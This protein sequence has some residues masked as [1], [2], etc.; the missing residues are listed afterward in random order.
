MGI[1]PTT[2]TF[3]AMAEEL[4][5]SVWSEVTGLFG[6]APRH[7]G[8]TPEQALLNTPNL[9]PHFIPRAPMSNANLDVGLLAALGHMGFKRGKEIT[10]ETHPQYHKAWV[11][12]CR[13]GGLAHIPQLILV[14][15]KIV[16]A[17]MIHGEEAG[18]VTTGLLKRLTFRE[19]IAVQGHEVGHEVSDHM[20]PRALAYT[21]LTLGGVLAGN[22]F[23]DKGGFGA[24][25]KQV[26]NPTLLRKFGQWVFGKGEKSSVLAA[27]AY[28]VGGGF[29]GSVAASQLTVHPTELDADRKGAHISGDPEG[30]ISALNKLEGPHKKRSA[31]GTIKHYFHFITSGYP[32]NETRTSRLREIA[33]TMPRDVPPV[34]A[35]I[36]T[37]P[38]A[39]SQTLAATPA[40]PAAQVS[41]ITG[42]ARVGAAEP[43]VAS[44]I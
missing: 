36:D 14:E 28:M 19:A 38:D 32:S 29:L 2:P 17:G 10:A 1:T 9:D 27:E 3:I 24:L 30:L 39:P 11:E 4:A 44:T 21:V 35:S 6:A 22:R 43:S 13:R 33:K 37:L 42:A 16:N 15:S 34:Y 7:Q 26:E 40:G 12:L 31:W 8:L 41:G 25:I 5:S 20:A 18:F 23:A